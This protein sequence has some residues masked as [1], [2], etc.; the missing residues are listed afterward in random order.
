PTRSSS[1]GATRKS[2]AERD[3]GRA[4]LN[5]SQFEVWQ[6]EVW[7]FEV[8][9]FGVWQ[10]GVWQFEVWQFDVWPPLKPATPAYR[11]SSRSL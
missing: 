11:G 1:A 6:F 4:T 10:F 8:W 5:L 9:Q 7:Q 3:Q 2:S